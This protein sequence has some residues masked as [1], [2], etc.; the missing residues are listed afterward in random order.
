[1]IPQFPDRLRRYATG[2]DGGEAWLKQLPTILED[3][4][5]RWNLELGPAMQEIKA[6]YVGYATMP[7]GRQV[8][9]KAGIARHIQPE[10]EA[11]RIYDGHGIN[12]II[13][14]DAE[15]NT[16]LLERFRP[17]TMLVE[18]GDTCE[19]AQIAGRIMKQL[20][21]VPPPAPDTFPHI[22]ARFEKS[23]HVAT[24]CSDL[25]RAR[26]YLDE[27]ARMEPMMRAL[28]REPQLLLHGDLHHYNILLD[29]KRSWTAIDPKGVIGPSCLDAGAYVGNAS[30][31]PTVEEKRALVVESVR[32][33]SRTSD[34]SEERVLAGAFFD[35]LVWSA[36]ALED[37]PDK[38]ETLRLQMLNIYR[39]LTAGL[40]LE[41]IAR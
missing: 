11:L 41:R 33:L 4:R 36:R 2:F 28:A 21:Q 16:M 7:D 27:L 29:D 5:S 8:V 32:E 31:A 19:K 6:N 26:P 37:A 17:G 34:E 22:G 14:H 24:Q 35:C 12:Q 10:A 9:I 13:D 3:C 25:E 30:M 38:D 23:M 15:L 39:D 1:M 18:L 40:D 20:Q